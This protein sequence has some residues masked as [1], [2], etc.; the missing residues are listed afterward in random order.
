M[1]EITTLDDLHSWEDLWSA[2]AAGDAPLRLLLKRSPACGI[3]RSAEGALGRL[4]G[5]L[6]DERGVLIHAVNVV[7]RRDVSRR[8]AS[9]TGVRH[10]SPQA[11]LLGPG[12]KVLWHESHGRL[13]L[14]ALTEALEEAGV[15]R[16]R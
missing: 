4:A 2:Q 9:D 16:Q 12:P 5:T 15:G 8:I 6:P 11:I 3:S 7:A 14:K 13:T 10:A 1:A